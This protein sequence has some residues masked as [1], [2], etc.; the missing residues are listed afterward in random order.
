MDNL[1]NLLA[2]GSLVSL[3]RQALRRLLQAWKACTRIVIK[4]IQGRTLLLS[5]SLLGLIRV[6]V[7]LSILMASTSPNQVLVIESFW[8]FNVI[9][10]VTKVIV[11]TKLT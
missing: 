5:N 2:I 1:C 7:V 6:V 11:A 8:I 9:I 10:V 4:P 3:I